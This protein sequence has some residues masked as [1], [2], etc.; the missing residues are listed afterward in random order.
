MA[1]KAKLPIYQPEALISLLKN[2][3]TLI[4]IIKIRNT[5]GQT[6]LQYV[7]GRSKA[8]IYKLIIHN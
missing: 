2:K 4:H 3:H 6:E 5:H 1:L 7:Y 8:A